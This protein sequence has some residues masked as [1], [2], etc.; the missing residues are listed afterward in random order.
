MLFGHTPYK[1]HLMHAKKLL[2]KKVA[3]R[4]NSYFSSFFL[5]FLL[6]IF[7]SYFFLYI[8]FFLSS[9]L[10][11]FFL[12]FFIFFFMAFLCLIPLVKAC[13]I[14]PHAVCKKIGETGFAQSPPVILDDQSLDVR[15]TLLAESSEFG[16]GEVNLLTNANR[17]V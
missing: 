12:S 16:F 8:T 15:F 17:A 11:L 5:S 10:C 4:K 7:F 9:F 13:S 14:F 2:R 1:I 6:F 3:Q